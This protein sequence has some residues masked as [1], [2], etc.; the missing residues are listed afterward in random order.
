M[1]KIQFGAGNI[2]F[3]TMT[4]IKLIPT[5]TYCRCCDETHLKSDQ[6]K[7][8][9]SE[10]HCKNLETFLNKHFETKIYNYEKNQSNLIAIS[11]NSSF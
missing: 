9:N 8:D 2:I 3:K 4:K 6:E 5:E 11:N 1:I 7:H 10:K